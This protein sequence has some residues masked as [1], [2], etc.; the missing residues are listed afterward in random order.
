MNYKKTYSN[1]FNQGYNKYGGN[2]ASLDYTINFINNNKVK[3]IVDIGSGT[4]SVIKLINKKYPSVK[5]VSCDLDKFHNI[6]CEFI[7]IDLSNSETYKSINGREF[8]LLTCLDVLEHLE[9]DHIDN[10]MLLFSK[11]C[12]NAIFT[13]ANH[14]DVQNGIELHTIIEDMSY[15][16]PNVTK[17]FEITSVKT[18]E[19]PQINGIN[20]LYVLTTK[21]KNK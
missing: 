14:S 21:S 5:V 18:Y 19:Y 13:I 11:L 3:S 4:G 9:K 17:Y 2:E 7:K 12:K 15:W 8:D 20:Y 16:E 6:N 10:V 1:L